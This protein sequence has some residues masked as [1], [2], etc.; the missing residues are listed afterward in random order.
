MFVQ[1]SS[2]ISNTTLT[3]ELFLLWMVYSMK[4]VG[5]KLVRRP[6]ELSR[7]ALKHPFFKNLVHEYTVFFIEVFIMTKL[8]LKWRQASPTC[9]PT[10]F[11][12]G[13]LRN[14]RLQKK[15]ESLTYIVGIFSWPTLSYIPV[16]IKTVTLF[17]KKKTLYEFLENDHERNELKHYFLVSMHIWCLNFCTPNRTRLFNKCLFLVWI[18]TFTS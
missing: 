8:F 1:R 7:L 14:A 11:T 4:V 9:K 2:L 15:K 5:T 17:G 18:N 13:L 10:F 6:D 3:L 12:K 16:S